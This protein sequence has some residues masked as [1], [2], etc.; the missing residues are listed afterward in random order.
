MSEVIVDRKTESCDT[1]VQ[2]PIDA[3]VV[4][5][6]MSAAADPLEQYQELYTQHQRRLFL[7]INAM[8]PC[9]ADADEVFQETNIIIWKKFDQFEI[10]TDF[11]A[12]A[13]RI[14]YF[15]VRDYRR[16]AWRRRTCFSPELIEQLAD[17]VQEEE[18]LLEDRRTALKDC[19]KNLNEADRELLNQCYAPG[20]K[21]QKIAAA[22][23]RK[24]TSIY[25][26]LRRI[27]QLLMDCI[28]A[29]T[30]QNA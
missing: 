11:L 22:S 4:D 8:L 7:Y 24:T 30:K 26:S 2:S 21:I 20:A 29:K 27:R 1:T 23:S 25:R 16:R 12:W 14:A 17:R 28:N 13:Y 18:E 3:P 10:G 15:Q 19:R 6:D 9:A 5:V